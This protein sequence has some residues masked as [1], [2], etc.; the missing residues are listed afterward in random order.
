M[1]KLRKAAVGVV[2]ALVA[3]AAPACSDASAAGTPMTVYATPTCGCCG[4][5]V[6]HARENG[7]DVRVV[8]HDDLRPIRAELGVPHAVTSCHT[9][10][11]D[12]YVVEG[13]VPADLV[14]RLLVERPDVRGI[15]VP[16]M[17]IGSPGMEH[18][19]GLTES[20][21]VVTFDSSGPLDVFEFR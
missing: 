7:F 5:W 4:A 21:E 2:I 10:V 16:G 17:P 15:A 8:Y 13:H 18:P 12:G 3:A 6:D 19:S 9:G 14:H 11:V 1:R 20:Y